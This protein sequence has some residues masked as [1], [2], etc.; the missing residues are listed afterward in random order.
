M[1]VG[2]D[3]VVGPVGPA[4]EL[5]VEDEQ[6]GVFVEGDLRI[7]YGDPQPVFGIPH[8]DRG[9]ERV[10]V[11]EQVVV[12]VRETDGRIDPEVGEESR[13]QG[14]FA[15]EER[16]RLF[17]S[18]EDGV[19]FR[20]GDRPDDRLANHPVQHEVNRVQDDP[21]YP[22][23]DVP[24]T[25][26]IL[27]PTVVVRWGPF[28]ARFDLVLVGGRLPGW[29]RRAPRRIEAVQHFVE[30]SAGAGRWCIG[31]RRR[32]GRARRVGLGDGGRWRGCQDHQDRETDP[33]G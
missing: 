24:G 11:G 30:R 13:K 3:P 21:R 8:G 15:V 31:H 32:G 10:S 2:A 1:G 28:V 29:K 19:G 17:D 20:A 26:R 7:T 5:A 16:Q 6:P 22:K 18:S 33:A 4:Q 14:G 12:R 25:F 23:Q 27:R 9:V